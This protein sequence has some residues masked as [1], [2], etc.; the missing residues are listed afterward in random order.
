MRVLL[1]TA[2]L[3]LVLCS[4]GVRRIDDRPADTGSSRQAADGQVCGTIAGIG[5]AAGSYCAIEPGECLRLSDVSGV[6]QKK[7]QMCT[8][9][10]NPVCGCEG[11]TYPNACAASAVGVSVGATGACPEKEDD[12]RP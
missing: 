2:A 3:V 8:Q 5:C 1:I 7:P 9:E 10:Y 11:R 12:K 4:C 6:C